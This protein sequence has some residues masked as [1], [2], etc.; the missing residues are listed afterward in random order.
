MIT[1]QLPHT[2][3]CTSSDTILITNQLVIRQRYR[4]SSNDSTYLKLSEETYSPDT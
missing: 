3:S 1:L 4:R 2:H